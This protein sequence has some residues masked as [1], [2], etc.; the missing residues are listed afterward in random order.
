MIP[1]YELFI[2]KVIESEV[3]VKYTQVPQN[4]TISNESYFTRQWFRKNQPAVVMM[5]DLYGQIEI[6]KQLSEYMENDHY[7]IPILAEGFYNVFRAYHS[8]PKNFDCF[9][10]MQSPLLT[11]QL[12]SFSRMGMKLG[13][14]D[15]QR[16]H[17][18]SVKLNRTLEFIGQQAALIE[19][20][21][22]DRIFK[23]STRGECTCVLNFDCVSKNLKEENDQ[24]KSLWDS[25][26]SP[27]I[28]D[29]FAWVGKCSSL[30]EY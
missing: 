16:F 25:T 27:S 14:N 13:D 20:V 1:L 3:C 2:Q 29:Y 17:H 5:G 12:N 9:K 28:D 23:L 22:F 4:W 10:D 30:G 6:I 21:R 26:W 11:T 15:Y 7:T 8:T 18:I 24:W 19:S